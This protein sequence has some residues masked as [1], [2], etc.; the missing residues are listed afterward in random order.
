MNDSEP[1]PQCPVSLHALRKPAVVE[2]FGSEGR[3]WPGWQ[4]DC[5]HCGVFVVEQLEYHHLVGY[6]N[7]DKV[8]GVAATSLQMKRHRAVMA[9]ALRRMA[10]SGKTPVLTD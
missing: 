8:P 7:A 10:A 1:I 2:A 9:H 3:N 5:L 4:F 6:L